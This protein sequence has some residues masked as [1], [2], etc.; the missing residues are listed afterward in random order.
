MLGTW[1]SYNTSQLEASNMRGDTM[2]GIKDQSQYNIVVLGDMRAGK[3][4]LVTQCIFNKWKA[5]YKPTIEDCYR[6]LARLPG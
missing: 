2:K 5:N 4:T 6:T 3:T 1:L